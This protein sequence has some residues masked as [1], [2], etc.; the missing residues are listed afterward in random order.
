MSKI[1]KNSDLILT[2]PKIIEVQIESPLETAAS[3]EP[4]EDPLEKIKAES[5]SILVETE[6]IVLDLLEKARAEA[7]NIISTAQEEADHVRAQVFEESK[8]IREE[9]A[10]QGYAEGLKRAQ[11]EIEADRQMAME[12]AQII[13]EDGRRLKHE[14][15]SNAEGDMVRLVLAIARKV[16]VADL[17]IQPEAITSIVREAITNLDN[18]DSVKVYV[19]PEDMHALVESLDWEGLTEIGSR[20]VEVEVKGDKRICRGG[21]V[22]ESSGGMVDARLEKRL[23]AVENMMLDVVNE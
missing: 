4:Q 17:S 6:Q 14:M 3:L 20:E 18:P 9:S 10:K 16:V 2:H 22:V 13:V 19:N 23:D 1:I 7:R 11:E 21:C 15:L 5:Q 12:Q 8:A